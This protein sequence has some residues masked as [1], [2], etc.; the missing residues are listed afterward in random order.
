[1]PYCS[2]LPLAGQSGLTDDAGEDWFTVRFR[3]LVNDHTTFFDRTRIYRKL[4]GRKRQRGWRNLVIDPETIGRLLDD[5]DQN[6][7]EL[8]V[9]PE[10]L[11][12]TGFR[13]L[14]ALEDIAV[15]L[16]TE[17]ADR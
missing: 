16:V 14:R 6:W 5:E 17:C 3:Y 12:T 10:R 15:E 9:P 2:S 1:M 8:Y 13:Q 7:Y 4:L 11:D